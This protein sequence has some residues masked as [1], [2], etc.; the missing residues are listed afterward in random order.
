MLEFGKGSMA[1]LDR[2]ILVSRRRI[3]RESP[4]E[5]SNLRTLRIGAKA[6]KACEY[7]VLLGRQTFAPSAHR[8]TT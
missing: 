8:Q 7:F 4:A 6:L 1:K 2:F 5:C 3:L